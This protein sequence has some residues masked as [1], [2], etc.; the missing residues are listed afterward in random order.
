MI[1]TLKQALFK[2]AY[3]LIAAAWLY[4]FS[5][6]FENYV[7]YTSVPNRVQQMLEQ[8][9]R[10]Q[11]RDFLNLLNDGK[12]LSLLVSP[13]NYLI[14]EEL[15]SKPYGLFVYETKPT[16]SLLY[17]NT[18]VTV[19]NY[20]HLS[21]VDS[22]Y[23]TQT[24]NGYYYMVRRAFSSPK[25]QYLVI[26]LIPVKW[27]FQRKT[28]YLEDDFAADKNINDQ[29]DISFSPTPYPIKSFTGRP[30]FYLSEK[31]DTLDKPEIVTVVF[32]FLAVICLL[33]CIHNISIELLNKQGFRKAFAFLL[34]CIFVLR[35]LSY[36]YSFLFDFEGYKLFSPDIYSSGFLY[37]SLGDLIIN[38]LL[39]F[40]VVVF[41]KNMVKGIPSLLLGMTDMKRKAIAWFAATLLVLF[42]LY[43]SQ[44]VRSLVVDSN[45]SFDVTNFFSLSIYTFISFVAISILLV[46]F[47]HLSQLLLL[48]VR[49]VYPSVLS[50]LLVVLIPGLIILTFAI[51]NP[52]THF[53]LAV[54]TWLLLYI[55]TVEL[56]RHKVYLTILKSPIFLFWMIF[57]SASAT[58][59]LIF[60]N[61]TREKI[62][63]ERFAER[64]AGQTDLSGEFMISLA[65]EGLDS[66]FFARTANHWV[67]P[68]SNAHLKDSILNESFSGYLTRYD[69]EIYTYDKYVKPLFNKNN[70]AYSEI[71]P[72]VNKQRPTSTPG[73]FH[74][75][76]APEKDGFVYHVT[77]QKADS[78]YGYFFIV[79]RP[80]AFKTEGLYP[81]LFKTKSGVNVA[82]EA[83][84][85]YAVYS[86]QQMIKN[87]NDYNFPIYIPTAEIP[88]W[89]AAEWRSKDGFEQLWYKARNDKVIV[90]VKRHSLFI[91]T[92]TLFA[93]FF[94]CFLMAATVLHIGSILLEGRFRDQSFRSLIRLNIR[95]QIQATVVFLMVFSFIVIG[96]A[97]ISFFIFRFENSNEERLSRTVEILRSEIESSS[98][99]RN[100]ISHSLVQA[101]SFSLR[102]IEEHLLQVSEL[103]NADAN[104]YNLDGSLR[105]STQPY[106]FNQHILNDRMNPV[107]YFQLHGNKR[108]KWIQE[109]SFRDFRYLSMYVP[110]RDS[111]GNARVYL[112]VPFLNS[113]TELQ[114]E[115]SNFLVTLINLNAFIFLM[116]AAIAVL[117]TNRIIKSFTLIGSK[118]REITL[119]KT[120]EI[121]KWSHDDEI[122][123]LV[124]E[125]NK[126]VKEL[127]ESA[128][129]LARTEREDAWRE[130]AK[131]VAHEIKNPL[132][133]MKLS[134]QYLQRA[135][136]TNADNVKEL[137]Q[138]VAGTLVQQIDQLARIASDFSQFANIN[139]TNR[140]TFNLTE[141]VQMVVNLHNA[142]S[143]VHIEH[144]IQPGTYHIAADKN[145][146]NR[147][148]T[149]LVKNAIEA[150]AKQPTAEIKVKQYHVDNTVI[151]SVRDNGSGISPQMWNKIFSPNFTTKSSGTGLGLAICKGIVENAGGSIWFE[152]E[153]NKGATFFVS[154][155]IAVS[156]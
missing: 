65:V 62:E 68:I 40:W 66:S 29:Y 118:M 156:Q 51:N 151:V 47:Y 30:L 28:R 105:S 69:T 113:Q 128:R 22:G 72:S 74:L 134:I 39:F 10:T 108:V 96:I 144:E 120:N 4:T 16:T 139:T 137:S 142:D 86:K 3:L 24:K 114:Q 80:R 42:T 60:E 14:K 98:L 127:E 129:Q 132:T 70:A 36:Y 27:K 63:R 84:Y 34:S 32:R 15:T 78:L 67:N 64:I 111:A 59:L 112:N 7:A 52:L 109:E 148:F 107:A 38:I 140:E 33:L 31:E 91:E 110:I 92:L 5:F 61:R 2:N 45:I 85:S 147:L 1:Q 124:K 146:V 49:M 153:E 82:T 6:I 26:G 9:I 71:I 35:V 13:R 102:M 83:D 94:C 77:M 37:P 155:P 130:M 79:A 125:Y 104:L 53:R 76:F 18:H 55:I 143:R 43:A 54:L 90:V 138:K 87:V 121:I 21:T 75:E 58:T 119:G 149:N 117:V 46:T 122:G 93:Y 56:E 57:F 154:L 11:E 97:T 106:I 25:N 50:H 19:P 17:W 126:M 44:L 145:Q 150:A 123:A 136:D 48:P 152:T 115:I 116:S 73:L 41:G 20:Q 99:S 135:I 141:V 12:T 100:G 131:Q 133:P 103:H 23:L 101:D 89:K 88:R 81:E 8:N 95:T